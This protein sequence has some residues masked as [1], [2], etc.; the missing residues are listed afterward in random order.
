MAERQG[1]SW[2]GALWAGNVPLAVAFWL[3][4]IAYGSVVNLVASLMALGLVVAGLP[5]WLATVMFLAPVPYNALALVGVWRSAG[6]WR[7]APTLRSAARIA[8]VA[9]AAAAMVL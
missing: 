6:R 7:G 2:V 1:L 3:Y 5:A 8:I 9:W 4:G